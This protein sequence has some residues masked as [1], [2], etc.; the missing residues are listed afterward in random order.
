MQN[1]NLLKSSESD[2]RLLKN[3]Q[4]SLKDLLIEK[5]LV[6]NIYEEKL[7]SY[8]WMLSADMANKLQLLFNELKCCTN[9]L[10]GLVTKSIGIANNDS[11]DINELLGFSETDDIYLIDTT[12]TNIANTA[13]IFNKDFVTNKMNEIK[14]FRQ[15]LSDVRK[16]LIDK[17]AECIASNSTCRTQ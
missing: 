4:H 14:I 13:A 3:Y 15:K 17:Y 7:K 11:I 1:C 8:D 12:L 10:T 9:E 6:K 5:D 2:K 16:N